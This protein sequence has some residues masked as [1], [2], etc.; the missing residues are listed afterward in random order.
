MMTETKPKKKG[1]LV[2]KLVMLV[3]IGVI[4]FS[5]Y[6]IGVILYGYYEGNNQ[7]EQVQQVAG[8]TDTERF[9]GSVDFESLLKENEDVKAGHIALIAL[10][11]N[12]LEKS[13][14]ILGFEAPEKM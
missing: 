6:K 7:Y 4:A 10:A 8:T 1:S 2:Y 12:V 9:Q 13:I 3:L 11:K 5:A 14:R